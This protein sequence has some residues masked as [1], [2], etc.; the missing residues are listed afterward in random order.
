MARK[1]EATP[2]LRGKAAK[3]FIADLKREPTI[4]EKKKFHETCEKTFSK[5]KFSH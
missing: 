4:K 1:I 3:K 2:T 5:I